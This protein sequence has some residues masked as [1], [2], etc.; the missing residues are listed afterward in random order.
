MS[1]KVTGSPWPPVTM[2]NGGWVTPVITLTDEFGGVSHIIEDDH[3][4]VLVNRVADNWAKSYYWFREAAE[5][6]VSLVK[7]EEIL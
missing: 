2:D 5:A 3:C 7:K 1:Y 4:F 6:L